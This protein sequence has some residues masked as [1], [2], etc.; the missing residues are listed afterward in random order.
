MTPT[1]TPCAG[2][3]ATLAREG[4]S[5]DSPVAAA[6]RGGRSFGVTPP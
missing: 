5:Q 3:P 4:V 2:S 1:N 6:L